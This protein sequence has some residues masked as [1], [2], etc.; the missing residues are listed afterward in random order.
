MEGAC[1]PVQYGRFSTPWRDC[2]EAE[3]SIA[4]FIEAAA[5]ANSGQPW[6]L[7]TSADHDR[8]G[9]YSVKWCYRQLRLSRKGSL[10]NALK[11]SFGTD[12]IRKRGV[13]LIDD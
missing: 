11:P 5:T 8:G 6:Y 9:T 1:K 13:R 3:M 2:S 4:A 12:K 10:R 7:S